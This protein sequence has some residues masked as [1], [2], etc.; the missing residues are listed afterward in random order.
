MSP[1]PGHLLC[2]AGLGRAACQA[3]GFDQGGFSCVPHCHLLIHSTAW[4]C[5]SPRWSPWTGAGERL[6]LP[7]QQ[8]PCQG[9]CSPAP[10]GEASLELSSQFSASAG[11]GL[12]QTHICFILQADFVL[13]TSPFVCAGCI[14]GLLCLTTHHFSCFLTSEMPGVTGE[15]MDGVGSMETGS[16]GCMETVLVA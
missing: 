11:Q 10:L 5:S 14:S 8:A 12:R 1:G 15:V 4:T 7:P 6:P 16:T 13:T 3:R 2:L 9:Q